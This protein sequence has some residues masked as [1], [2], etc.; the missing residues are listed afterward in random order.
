MYSKKG[1]KKYEDVNKYVIAIHGRVTTN[2]DK[3]KESQLHHERIDSEVIH[4]VRD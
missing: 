3:I 2:K 1:K 4:G